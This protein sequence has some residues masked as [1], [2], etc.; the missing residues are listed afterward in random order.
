[1]D[2]RRDLSLEKKSISSPK[3]KIIDSEDVIFLVACSTTGGRESCW[4]VCSDNYKLFEDVM[5]AQVYAEMIA[6][7]TMRQHQP[8]TTQLKTIESSGDSQNILYE[9]QVRELANPTKVIQR[10]MIRALVIMPS[11]R[12]LLSSPTHFP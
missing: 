6:G 2:G 5:D 11:S 9:Y 10:I 12:P 3:T 1:M 4:S 7:E 8:L